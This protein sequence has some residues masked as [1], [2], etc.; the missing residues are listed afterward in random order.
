MVNLL[1]RTI[2]L[3]ASWPFRAPAAYR[4]AKAWGHD[5]YDDCF[6]HDEDR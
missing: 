4:T 6:E 3:A 5:P 1:I 2:G